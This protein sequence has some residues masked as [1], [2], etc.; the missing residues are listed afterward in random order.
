MRFFKG[1]NESNWSDQ[2]GNKIHNWKLKAQNVWFVNN[3]KFRLTEGV[4]K[5]GKKSVLQSAQ[6]TVD[7]ALKL[8]QE[9]YGT[10]ANI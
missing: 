2:R 6:E 5:L 9:Q 10:D 3:D 1:Y 7:G 8:I 4:Q